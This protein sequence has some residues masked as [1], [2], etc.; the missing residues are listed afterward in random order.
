[1]AAHAMPTVLRKNPYLRTTEGNRGLSNAINP[2]LVDVSIADDWKNEF[3][4][5]DPIACKI[6]DLYVSE[7]RKCLVLATMDMPGLVAMCQA[8]ATYLRA[9][10]EIG[11]VARAGEW[12]KLVYEK[13]GN[14]RGVMAVGNRT[15]DQ[16]KDLIVQFGGFPAARARMAALNTQGDLFTDPDTMDDHALDSALADTANNILPFA[17]SR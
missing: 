5:D 4:G 11:Q 10:R 17:Q 9:A 13:G 8:T 15:F 3:L 2:P 1:M 14:Y 16:A 6:W 7:G 12:S